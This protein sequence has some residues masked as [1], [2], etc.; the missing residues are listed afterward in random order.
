MKGTRAMLILRAVRRDTGGLVSMSM[1]DGALAISCSRAGS[2]VGELALCA[3]RPQIRVGNAAARCAIVI[4]V[5]IAQMPSPVAGMRAT[6]DGR[7]WSPQADCRWRKCVPSKLRCA[8]PAL[9][10]RSVQ[11]KFRGW[12][13]SGAQMR[14]PHSEC[15]VSRPL[16]LR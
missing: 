2:P 11:P 16:V 4:A 12:T 1:A 7:E 6:V 8:H 14:T 13:A 15:S 3:M 9:V 5:S 10:R